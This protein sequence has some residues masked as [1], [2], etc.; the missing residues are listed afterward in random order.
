M[1]NSWGRRRTTHWHTD[2]VTQT[3]MLLLRQLITARIG[4]GAREALTEPTSIALFGAVNALLTL[5]FRI[6]LLLWASAVTLTHRYEV[7]WRLCSPSLLWPPL[8]LLLLLL[9]ADAIV[10][11]YLP[12]SL[13]LALLLLLARSLGRSVGLLGSEFTV[14]LS[15]CAH[16]GSVKC[17]GGREQRRVRNFHAL[18][19]RFSGFFKFFNCA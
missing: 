17:I 7:S 4:V 12:L 10:A 3:T 13:A 18:N 14:K 6:R 1:F 16:Q 2:T 5:L 11:C 15:A 9:A 8:P 19:S